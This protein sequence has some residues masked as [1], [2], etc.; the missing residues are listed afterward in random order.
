MI[1]KEYITFGDKLIGKVIS[2][3]T[4]RVNENFV[5]TDVAL[6]SKLHF[7]PLSISQLLEDEY[8]VRFKRG[9]SCVLDA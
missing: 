5:L 2:R 4:I 8:E 6:V 9:L 7:N 1:G 3:G